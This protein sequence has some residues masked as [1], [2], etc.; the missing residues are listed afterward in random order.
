MASINDDFL[1]TLLMESYIKILGLWGL[2]LFGDTVPILYFK[3]MALELPNIRNVVFTLIFMQCFYY[4]SKLAKLC[5]LGDY[6]F[7]KYPKALCAP[8]F[9]K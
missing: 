9:L 8:V 7:R 5:I 4:K 2:Q 1:R 6:I 3:N